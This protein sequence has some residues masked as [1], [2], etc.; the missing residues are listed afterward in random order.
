MYGR[1][2]LLTRANHLRETIRQQSFDGKFFVDNAVRKQAKLEVTDNRTEVC[3]YFA[4]F[5]DVANP[6][7]HGKLWDTLRQ[8]FGPAR[9]GTK[10]YPQVHPANSFVGNYLRLELLSRFGYSRQV[11]DELIDFFLYM[12]ERTGT[13]WEHTRTSASCNHGFASH[14]AHCLYRDVLGV[15]RVDT[16]NKIVELRFSDVELEWCEGRIPTPDGPIKVR[17]WAEGDKIRYEADVPAG[18]VLKVE[19]LTSRKLTRASTF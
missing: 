15:R 13:L 16:Q 9:A 19:N 2:A 12:A 3:Q 8:Q 18:Y 1:P 7:T 6:G 5:F 11:K 10:A 17:W 14:V 4:F